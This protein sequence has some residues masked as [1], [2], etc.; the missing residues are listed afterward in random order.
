MHPT[1]IQQLALQRQAEYRQEADNHRLAMLARQ[2]NDRNDALASLRRTID[3]LI[4]P[5]RTSGTSPA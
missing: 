5:L 4:H 1:T 2:G 3:L